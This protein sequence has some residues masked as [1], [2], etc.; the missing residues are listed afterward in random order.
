[1][2]STCSK[3]QGVNN[4]SGSKQPNQQYGL[5]LC[6]EGKHPKSHVRGDA[7]GGGRAV[8]FNNHFRSRHGA[9]K[10]LLGHRDR[11][12]LF[13]SFRLETFLVP[14]GLL[15]IFERDALLWVF[16]H[17]FA[18]QQFDLLGKPDRT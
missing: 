12:V 7:R 17:D 14:R 11:R 16:G 1:M 18:Q 10:L 13:W 4:D 8:H 5:R 9:S 6:T 2:H 3:S 15:D